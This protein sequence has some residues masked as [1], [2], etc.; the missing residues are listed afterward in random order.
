MP[1]QLLATIPYLQN[2]IIR[3][4]AT[5]TL[6]ISVECGEPVQLSYFGGLRIGQVEKAE[7][8]DDNG[9][10]IASLTDLA[11]MKVYFVTQRAE[12]KDYLDI[13][14]LLTQAKIPLPLM[15]SAA[16]LIYGAEFNPLIALK[17]ISYFED[18]ALKDL[19]LSIQSDLSKMVKTV[20]VSHLPQLK[21]V[22]TRP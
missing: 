17:A 12:I 3:Q 1:Q 22:R 18:E 2:A 5:N 19:S 7:P 6:S 10:K 9:I 15:L 20:N 14:A 21:A 16:T 8:T 4:S 13:H 11:G